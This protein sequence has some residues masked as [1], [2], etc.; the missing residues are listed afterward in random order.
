MVTSTYN[1]PQI[2]VK[3]QIELLKSDGL[4]FQDE[5]RARH[6]LENV[7]MF[8]MKNY[9]NPFRQRGNRRFRK[10]TTFDDVYKI[11]MFD[12]ELRN[13]VYSELE[14]I[15]IS[16]RTQL[17]LIMG[18]VAGIYWF[19]DSS[20]FRNTNRHILLLNKLADELRR[21]DDEA[22]V[23]FKRRYSNP[24]P[25]SWI[26]FEVSSFGTL[27]MM[28]RWI[29]AG[30]ARR[31]VARFYGLSDT[32]MESWLHSIVYVRNICTHHSRLWNR[33]LSINA[34]IPRRTLKP[35]INIPKETKKVYYVLSIILY[36]LE[37]V[38]SENTFVARFKV[39]LTKYPSVDVSAMGFPSN[40]NDNELWK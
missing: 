38:N 26:T 15:E 21:S 5:E 17:S 28:Y 37:T 14:K 11:Y 19:E 6:L 23:A 20:N 12:S 27:S 18:D 36:F 2:S 7:S 16:I 24:F 32:V 25:P 8:R 31:K 9:L 40:W 29:N 35:F 3:D 22:I 10:N 33:K 34:M 30:K 13:L 1:Q 39:L 4:I